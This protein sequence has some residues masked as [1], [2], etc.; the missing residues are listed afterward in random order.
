MRIQTSQLE[1]VLWIARLGSFRAAAAQ[2]NLSQPTISMRVRELEHHLG[3][4]LFDRSGY[5][6][7]L[8]EAGRETVRLAER[9]LSLAEEMEQRSAQSLTLAE[10][11]RLG[12]VDSFALT[13]LPALLAQLEEKFPHLRVE[14]LID[15]SFNL[16]RRLQRGELDVAFLTGPVDGQALW[17]EPLVRQPLAWIAS[18]HLPLPARVLRPDD[19]CGLAILTNPG[20]SHLFRAVQDW[21]AAA[22]VKPERIMT[23]NSLT[24]MARLV[25]SGFAITLLPIGI[26]RPELALGTLRLLRTAP[27]VN[28]HELLM[29]SRESVPASLRSMIRDIALHLVRASDLGDG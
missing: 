7:R 21:F 20:P 19:L 12:A 27:Q 28:P 29:V 1:A 2:L 26:L 14:L 24:I 18:P 23:C 4:T 5:R 25:A 22:D 10:P 8:T 17:V 11:I 16:N 6:A 13:L 15:F 9:I 3:I